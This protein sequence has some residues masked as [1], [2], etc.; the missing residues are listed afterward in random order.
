MSWGGGEDPSG[1][2]FQTQF[3]RDAPQIE[4]RKMGLMGAAQQ[5]ARFGQNPWELST[6]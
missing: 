6:P 3:T 2:T 1:T 4:A 5:Y